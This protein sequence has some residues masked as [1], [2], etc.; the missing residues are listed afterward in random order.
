HPFGDLAGVGVEH[1][2]AVRSIFGEPQ[3]ILRIEAA[4]PRLRAGG[5]RRPDRDLAGLGVTTAD[6]RARELQ[7]KDVVVVV[8]RHAV[9]AD[10]LAARVLGNAAVLV[11][12]AVR[13]QPNI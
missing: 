5:R 11:F 8:G 13:V 6:A 10:V 9:A 3:T 12:A 4:A 2:Y 7:H 1:G